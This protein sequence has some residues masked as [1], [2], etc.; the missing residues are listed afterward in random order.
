MNGDRSS[1]NVEPGRKK[2]IDYIALSACDVLHDNLVDWGDYERLRVTLL[3]M[4]CF[5][6]FCRAAIS[7]TSSLVP[8]GTSGSPESEAI[9]ADCC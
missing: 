4:R 6:S 1:S 5:C 8:R 2:L 7:G 3:T 9:P